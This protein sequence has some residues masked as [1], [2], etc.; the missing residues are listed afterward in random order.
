[1]ILLFIARSFFSRLQYLS[2]K[3]EK[4]ER[5]VF[6]L[7]NMTSPIISLFLRD[8]RIPFPFRHAVFTS[9]QAVFPCNTW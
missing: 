4:K 7:S 6:K 1:M 2:R 5:F 8:L 3:E 9:S